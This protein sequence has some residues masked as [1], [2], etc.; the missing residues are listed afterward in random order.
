MTQRV[1]VVKEYP[2]KRIV[3]HFLFKH[4]AFLCL[5]P[6]CRFRCVD[7]SLITGNND[8]PRPGHRTVENTVRIVLSSGE[9]EPLQLVVRTLV[10]DFKTVMGFEPEIVNSLDKVGIAAVLVVQNDATQKEIG[11]SNNP[12]PLDGFES[13]RVSESVR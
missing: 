8:R 1:R 7:A 9:P 12:P 3:F 4:Y 13:H 10:R 5:L 6:T 2:D 11:R